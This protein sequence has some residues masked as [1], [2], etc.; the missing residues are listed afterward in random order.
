MTPSAPNPASD[1][2]ATRQRVLE[3]AKT[4]ATPPLGA[5]RL[6]YADLGRA[7]KALNIKLKPPAYRY[8]GTTTGRYTFGLCPASPRYEIR[9]GKYVRVN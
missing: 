2:A 3:L 7:M 4:F 9:N 6:T 5:S 8:I 1:W